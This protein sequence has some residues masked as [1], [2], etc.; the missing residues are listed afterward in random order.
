M[1]KQISENI[2]LTEVSIRL[3]LVCE[4]PQLEKEASLRLRLVC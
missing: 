3:R 2:R 1:T 4:G